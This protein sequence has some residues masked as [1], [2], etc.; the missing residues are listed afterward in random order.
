MSYC[1]N[2]ACTNP[3][4]LPQDVECQA[5]GSQLLLNNRYR[6]TRILGRGG[7]ATTFLADDEGLPGRPNCVIKQLRPA[8]SAPHIL[9]MSR[10]LFQREAVTLGKVG[11]HPQL[12]RLLDYFELDQEFYLIQDYIA[13]ATLQQEVRRS[14]PFEEEMVRQV[15]VE[16]LPILEY[17]HS[18]Q[19]IHR[20]IKPANIIRRTIDEKLV[21]IDFG[22]VKDQVSQVAINSIQDHTAFTAF[23]VGTP[24]FAPPEQMAMRPIY[25]SDVYSLGVTCI[26]L[27]TGKSPKDLNYDPKTG[28]LQ[29][30]DRVYVSD[31][32]LQVL[33]KML[34]V[35][36]RERYQSAPEVLEALK[37]AEQTDSANLMQALS[38]SSTYGAARSIAGTPSGEH[39]GT[40]VSPSARIAERIRAQQS[41]LGTTTSV[42]SRSSSGGMS[43]VSRS[44]SPDW[45]P[46]ETVRNDKISERSLLAAFN[47]GHRDFTGKDLQNCQL[48]KAQLV[49]IVLDGAQMQQINFKQANL[50]DAQMGRTNLSSAQLAKAKLIKTYLSYA[51]LQG[52]DLRGADL[53]YAHL[54]NANLRGANL[55]GANLTGATVSEG[56]LAL[57]R[58][59]GTTIMPNGKRIKRFGI[60]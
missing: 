19:V 29:W 26:Y 12:P 49:G 34:E 23:A 40:T 44:E 18:Q 59:N 28:E 52:A 45:A 16:V 22:A 48:S 57:A 51:D 55:C 2:P 1:L 21:L 4:N 6:P 14:G 60:I 31:R 24:G 15:L 8:L 11:N 13:G 9:E 36:P 17:L 47:R 32:F 43:R 38:S 3:N 50:C 46:R 54:T 35:S 7:F 53:S 5:C 20:D 25:A 39:R 41:R 27:L 42:P 10:E 58:L 30:K 37:R 56:Q 33:E